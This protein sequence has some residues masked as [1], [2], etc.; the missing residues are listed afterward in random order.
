MSVPIVFSMAPVTLNRV[1]ATGSVACLPVR[2]KAGNHLKIR[3]APTVCSDTSLQITDVLDV[4]HA[5]RY[6]DV[7]LGGGGMSLL[8]K[9]TLLKRHE[10]T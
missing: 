7:T 3:R 1:S 9:A 2:K 8:R 4:P 6:K 10:R 5:I